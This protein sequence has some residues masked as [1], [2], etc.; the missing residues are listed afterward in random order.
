VKTK[1]EK[2][3]YKFFTK[4][5]ENLPTICVPH[6]SIQYQDCLLSHLNSS[7]Q[8]AFSRPLSE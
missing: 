6:K 7:K 2:F 3:T 5:G 4:T 1:A 8:R